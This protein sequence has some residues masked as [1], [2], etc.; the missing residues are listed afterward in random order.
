MKFE[1]PEPLS[2]DDLARELGSA[3]PARMTTAIIAAALHDR[4]QPYVESLIVRFLQHNDPDVRRAAALAAG[5][6]ARIHRALSVD[7]LVPLLERLLSD[8]QVGG[9]AQDALDDIRMF[10]GKP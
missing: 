10:L 9:T 2:R 6:V 8:P 5:H 3:D 1:Q 7:R 4:D